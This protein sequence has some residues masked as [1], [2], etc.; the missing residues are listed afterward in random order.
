MAELSQTAA[1]IKKFDLNK[2][3]LK[4]VSLND[5]KA[6]NLNRDTQLFERGIDA[7]GNLI[8]PEYT[9][10]TVSLKQFSG[11]VAD[12]VTLRDTEAFHNSFLMD[13]ASFP[14]EI[15]ASD[16]K[17]G[18]LKSKY[19]DDIFGLTNESQSVFNKHILEDVQNVY[20]KAIGIL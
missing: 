19:G 17:T 12:H 1:R 7:E 5:Q 8:T 2:E 16:P 9:P 6:L 18:E 15:T 10:F 4:V 13:A 20:K 11:Q 14:V 3:I